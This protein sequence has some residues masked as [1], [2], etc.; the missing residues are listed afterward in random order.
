VILQV[1][2]SVPK[3]FSLAIVIVLHRRGGESV[4]TELLT[5]KTVLPVKEVEEKDEILSGNVY[6]APADYHLLIENDRT[7]SLDYSEKVNYSRPSIDVSFES[8][9]EVYGNKLI[10]MLLSGAN[11]DG[12]EG[13]KRIKELGGLVVV[14]NPSEASVSYMPQQ[15][16]D[17]VQVDYVFDTNGIKHFFQKLK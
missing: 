4:L 12:T 3:N 14:Q 5:E 17:D 15:A 2:P 16:L 11:A 9:A 6:I 7:F 10:G 8:A 13:L 1:L